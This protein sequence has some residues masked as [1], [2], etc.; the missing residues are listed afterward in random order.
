MRKKSQVAQ[1]KRGQLFLLV[2]ARDREKGGGSKKL[3]ES[4][5]DDVSTLGQNNFKMKA[6]EVG[7]VSKEERDCLS[8]CCLSLFKRS[9]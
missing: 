7:F 2:R 8:L 1:V 5:L 4:D 6:A 3:N 9:R